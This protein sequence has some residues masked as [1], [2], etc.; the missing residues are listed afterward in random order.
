MKFYNHPSYIGYAKTSKKKN[1]KKLKK[2][3]SKFG[4][5]DAVT[6][7]LDT[8]IS[9]FI[10]PRLKRWYKI[11]DNIILLDEYKGLREAIE[12]MIQG[13]EIASK[14][15]INSKEDFEKVQKAFLNL[16][17]WFNHLWI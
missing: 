7:N 4:F 10:L 11:S 3:F 8:S 2:Q 17:I 13:F 1:Q 16:S 14:D 5:D 12:E 15:E 6:W 9:I